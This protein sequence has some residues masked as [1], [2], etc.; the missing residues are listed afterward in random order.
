MLTEPVAASD[1]REILGIARQFADAHFAIAQVRTAA[2]TPQGHDQVVWKQMATMGWAGVGLPDEVGGSDLGAVVQCVL[3]RELAGRLAPSP[4][5]STAAFSA[6]AL[7]ALA[8]R[9]ATGDLLSRIA[10]GTTTC[11]LAWGRSRGWSEALEVGAASVWAVRTGDAWRMDGCCDLVLE[12]DQSNVLVVLAGTGPGT[13]G[14]FTVDASA[15]GVRR[16]A[17]T[18]DIT[19]SVA[20]VELSG[21]PGRLVS[22]PDLSDAAVLAVV[23][24][25]AV[26]LSAELIGTATAAVRTTLDYLRTR[27]Q[28]GRP[29]GAFQ[30]L[31][32]RMADLAVALTVAQEFVFAAAEA[33]DNRQPCALRLAAPLALARAGEV[34]KLATEEAIQL[35][36]AVGFTDELELGLYYK[37][38]L[39]D[40]EL[41]ATP[42][43]AHARVVCVRSGGGR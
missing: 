8:E 40:I 20:T 5:L 24:R 15:P 30:A 25:L 18:I 37:R 39:S 4:F 36:G 32:H 23:D 42:A 6:S 43:E 22:A 11:S 29:I 17:R 13:W 16:G 35:H 34:A 1:H 7:S 2:M 38:V 9:G 12:A 3:H 31:K 41:I 28:F 14:L 10:D 19:R 26:F 33:V 27:Q 21:T